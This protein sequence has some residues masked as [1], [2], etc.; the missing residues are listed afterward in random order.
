M[1]YLK[2]FAEKIEQNDYPGFLKIWEEFCYN[3]EINAEELKNILQLTKNSDLASSFG[4]HVVRAIPLWREIKNTFLRHEILKLIFDIQNTNSEELADLAYSYLQEKY[5]KDKYFDLK[6]RM[7]GLRGKQNFQGA[8]ANYEL[9]SHVNKGKFVFHTA[10]W[11]TGEIIDFSLIREEM[12]LEFDFVVEQKHLSFTNA[13]KTLIP[14]KDNHFLAQRFGNPDAFEQFARKKPIE[15]IRSLLQD[16]GPKTATEIKDELCDLVIPEKDW[17]KWWQSLRMKI[18][19]DTKIQTPKNSSLPFSILKEDISHEETFY[20][21]LENKP[22]IEETLQIVHTYLKDFPEMGKNP[23]WA[24]SLVIKLQELLTFKE[25]TLSQ[26]IQLKFFLIDLKEKKYLSE[27]ITLIKDCLSCVKL[28]NSIKIFS[29]K[30][31]ILSLIKKERK[32][33][34]NIFFSLLF[35]CS[36]NILRDFLLYEIDDQNLLKKHV[37]DLL[38][39][40]ITYP[41]VFIWYFQKIIEKKNN[42]PFS[43]DTGKKQFF[44]GFLIL[45]DHL[46]NK[47][48]FREL[49]KKMVRILTNNRYQIVRNIIQKATLEEVKEYLLLST[50]CRILNDHDIKIIHSLA[51]VAYPSLKNQNKKEENSSKI[52]WTTQEGYKK[53]HEK[54]SYL[55]S[56]ETIKN[57]KEIEEARSHGDLKENAEYKASLERRDRIQGELKLLSD[58]F[59]SMRI[60]TPSDVSLEKIG[61]G[62]IIACKTTHGEKKNYTILGPWEANP[63]KGILSFDSKLAKKMEGLKVGDTFLF[64]EKKYQILSIKSFFDQKK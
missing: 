9:L 58:Q 2:L 22:S 1:G 10:G 13:F 64:Q 33:W 57:A 3:E 12:T 21:A 28:V 52:L 61:V 20:K 5:P 7:I 27:I 19:K 62:S 59:N 14:L 41:H 15:V 47:S 42:L 30:K 53:L 31:R 54:I 48:E 16:L 39:H 36:Q 26:T 50:K 55:S 4:H 63:E 60:L 29:M 34:Q 8:I 51:I 18:K 17:A 49:S 40:P 44:E 35:S 6:I 23:E 38:I 25:L 43:D 56:T 11:G 45:L 37:A 32:D 46:G 24:A